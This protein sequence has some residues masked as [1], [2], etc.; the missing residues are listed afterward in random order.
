[1]YKPIS[2]RTFSLWAF[3]ASIEGFLA[4]FFVVGEPSEAESA[5]LFGLSL[6]RLL[7]AISV[8]FFAI[9]FLVIA[10]AHFYRLLS[11]NEPLNNRPE[12]IR[13][14]LAG[15]FVLEWIVFHF[16]FLIPDY[17]FPTLLGYMPRLQPVLIWLALLF[18]QTFVFLVY[19]RGLAL[20]SGNGWRG[21]K[22]VWIVLV[23]IEFTWAF[24][25]FTGLGIVPDE[26][27]WNVAGVPLLAGQVW[28]A[29]GVTLF[30]GF[31]FERIVGRKRWTQVSSF[32]IFIGIWIIAAVV[33]I[34]TPLGATFNAPGP[35]LPDR[36]FY[37]FVDAALFDIGAQSAVY[38]KGLFFGNFIDRGLLSGFL[39]LIHRIFGQDYLVVVAVQSAAYAVFPALLYLLGKKIHSKAAGVLIAALAIFKVSNAITGGKLI[40]TSHPKLMLTEFPTGVVLIVIALFLVQWLDNPKAYYLAG[41]G[42]SIGVGILLRHNV[43]FMLPV[44]F[45]MGFFIWRLRW[46]LALR[47]VFLVVVAFFITISPWM[48]RNQRV[49]GEP[50]FFL[51]QFD[52]VIQERYEQSS[53]E[54]SALAPIDSRGAPKTQLVISVPK[55]HNPIDLTR[56]Q[57]IPQ[58][59]M[60][61]LITSVLTL[62]PSPIL[63]D[64]RHVLDA[65]PYWGRMQDSSLGD[66]SNAGGIFLAVNLTILSIGIGT[67]W[68]RVRYA[69]LVPLMVFLFYNLAN[70]FARTSGGRYVVPI[71]WVIYF[72]YAIGLVEMIRFCISALGFHANG[73]FKRPVD[74][75]PE[76]GIARLN[77][78]K[79]GLVILPFFLIVATLPL[80]EWTSPGEKPP[81]TAQSLLGKLDKNSFFEQSGFSRQEVEE[82]LGNPD[83]LLIAGRGLYP[84]YYSYDQGEPILPGQMTPY[85]PRKFPRLVFT[86]L[87]P[88]M[89]KTVLLPLDQRK[90]NFPDAAEVIVGGCQVGKRRNDILAPYLT[91]ID[92]AFIMVVDKNEKGEIYTRMPEAPLTCPLREPVCDNNH[93]CH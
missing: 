29:I 51:Q 84:R 3:I 47:D 75:K 77:W 59:F 71:D 68:K 14:V 83:A 17:R 55:N 18:A 23:I 89:N 67:A 15:T 63:D 39:A 5:I 64:L 11:W 65:Y 56:Y 80:L 92:A 8:L 12:L 70:A 57:F 31:L 7:I 30:A 16:L 24:V 73:F 37:P 2:S 61:N 74:R 87:L 62:P 38:G 42:A 90:L 6:Q 88:D 34:T 27:Y 36:A 40:S 33:W 58:H 4:L 10:I 66:V 44:T 91:Y 1:M 28:L 76:Q 48:W 26:L 79:T 78:S 13:Y 21:H 69:A 81:E 22:P 93:N 45:I 32:A 86:L 54:Q 60:H 49:A 72:Y 9:F 50:F 46:K 52:R 41:V 25:A 82:F 20:E 43:F 85:T 19:H 35:Y 53:I